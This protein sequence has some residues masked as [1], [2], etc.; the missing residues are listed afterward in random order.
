MSYIQDE[1][2]KNVKIISVRY[3]A[4]RSNPLFRRSVHIRASDGDMSKLGE[5]YDKFDFA[6]FSNEI[7]AKSTPGI[8]SYGDAPVEQIATPF[9]WDIDK[10]VFDITAESRDHTGI[11][12]SIIHGYTDKY[13]PTFSGKLDPNTM[14]FVDSV[15]N[16]KASIDPMTGIIGAPTVV[17]A[18]NVMVDPMTGFKD[19]VKDLSIGNHVAI[20]PEDIIL[21]MAVN[22]IGEQDNELT[23]NIT[24]LAG[25]NQHATVAKMKDMNPLNNLGE[26]LTSITKENS[27]SDLY[28]NSTDKLLNTTAYSIEYRVDDQAFFKRM[29]NITHTARVGSFTLNELEQSF[30]D[31]TN[32]SD[33][34]IPSGGNHGSFTMDGD[35]SGAVSVSA[36]KSNMFLDA[37]ISYLRK[38]GIIDVSFT[39]TNK[40]LDGTTNAMILTPPSSNEV[41]M[42]IVSA[43]NKSLEDIKQFAFPL[44]AQNRYVVT[45]SLMLSRTDALVNIQFDG[46]QMESFSFPLIAYSLS[47]PVIGTEVEAKLIT[48]SISAIN[49]FVIGDYHE[50][51]KS[52]EFIY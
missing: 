15:T 18:Y 35:S 20:R 22:K 19:Y 32:V 30:G 13:D 1:L 41:N 33:L 51:D 5:N 8:V 42:N 21:S 50:H 47:T 2:T 27:S 23:P 43:M 4:I 31:V 52:D 40:T 7:L 46:G 39:I 26:V 6:A 14:F 11:Y 9:G 3:L 48:E 12:R 45:V 25:I 10:L 38:Y 34:I 17:S 29:S 44:V 28:T 36:S 24:T 49:D 37:C 16:T